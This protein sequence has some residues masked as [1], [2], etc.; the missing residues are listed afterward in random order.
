MNPT[1]IKETKY[2]V[3]Y[4]HNYTREEILAVASSLEEAREKQKEIGKMINNP[5]DM[6]EYNFLNAIIKLRGE[7]IGLEKTYIVPIT[8]INGIALTYCEEFE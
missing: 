8:F 2:Y 5:H 6:Y 4:C 7:I 3:M 1:P